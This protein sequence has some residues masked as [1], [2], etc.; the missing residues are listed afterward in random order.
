MT[1]T[2]LDPRTGQRVILSLPD[3]PAV[4]QPTPALVIGHLR[5]ATGRAK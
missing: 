5:L 3:H 1:L 4:Q 2:V